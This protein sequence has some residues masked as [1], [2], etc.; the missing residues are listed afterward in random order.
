VEVLGGGVRM[1]IVQQ[2]IVEVMGEG[3]ILGAKFD[4]SSVALGAAL[5]ANQKD[6]KLS[7]SDADSS[8]GL[9]EGE[10]ETARYV[11]VYI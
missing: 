6:L 2:A 9:I 5:L 8:L 3:T 4:D 7:Y 1:Q 11:Y 10:I